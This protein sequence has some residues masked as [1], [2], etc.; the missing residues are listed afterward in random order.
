MLFSIIHVQSLAQSSG[1]IWLTTTDKTSLFRQQKE[2]LRFQKAESLPLNILIDS[3]Q[4]FQAMDGFGFTLT[5]GSAQHLLGMS[6]EKRT[7]LLKELFS[8]KGNGIGMD[9][10]RISIGASDLNQTVFSYDDLPDG[11]TDSELKKFDLGADRKDVIPILKEILAINPKIKILGSPWSPPVW[12]KDNND[13]RG[14]SLKPEF[15]DAYARYFVRYIQQMASEGIRIDAITVQNEPLHPGNNPSLLMPAKEQ[16]TFVGKYLGPSFKTARIDTKIIIYDHNAD[17]PE[18][19]ISILD[20]PEA[21]KYI[22][23]S[24]FHLYGGKIDALSQVHQAHPDKNL[25]F[26]EQW[27][28]GPGNFAKDFVD[29]IKKLTIGASRNWSKTVLEW[30]LSSDPEYK[31]FTDRGGCS[32]C[33]GGITIDKDQVTRNAAYY[34]VG[35]ASKFVRAGSVRIASNYVNELPNV[36]FRTPQGKTVLI[37]LN[38]TDKS[39]TFSIQSEKKTAQTSLKPGAVATY[40][41]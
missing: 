37:V 32:K 23:G 12:M 2:G 10:L 26:T 29:H 7:Q 15:Y 35:H 16:A 9:Y 13:T 38:D 27:M 19:P 31:P 28:G 17:K 39:Q 20:D 11:Q 5:G 14:G 22:D 21:R 41:W 33:L 1:A 8:L 18:Y 30:N 34:V 4:T 36:A 25:Y 3:K 24:A 40:V 6:Q